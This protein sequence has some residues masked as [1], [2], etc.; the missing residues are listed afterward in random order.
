MGHQLNFFLKPSDL[1][2][3]EARLATAVPLT[4]LHSRSPNEAPQFVR[5]MVPQ[6]SE[7]AW[8]YFYLVHPDAVADVVARHVPNQ[9]Y[10]VIDAL[11]SPVVEFNCC[12]S[13][14]AIIRRGRVFYDEKFYDESGILVSKSEE[15]CKWAKMIFAQIKKVVKKH[16]GDYI[17]PAASEWLA[18]SPS[19][20]LVKF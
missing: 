13:D 11:R 19:A 10:W 3:V 12:Y 1:V 20:R 8:L 2:A 9:G 7:Q 6:G 4:I 17:G 16:D 14:E 18:A 15:F 5:S